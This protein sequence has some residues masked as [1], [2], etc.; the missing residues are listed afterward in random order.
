ML[1]PVV[2]NSGACMHAYWNLLQL[3]TAHGLAKTCKSHNFI[4]ILNMF[5]VLLANL[6]CL[7]IPPKTD[8]CAYSQKSIK[9]LSLFLWSM[10]LSDWNKLGLLTHCLSL[11][12]RYVI[13]LATGSFSDMCHSTKCSATSEHEPQHPTANFSWKGESTSYFQTQGS[14]DVTN[15]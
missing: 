11:V 8:P 2:K 10:Q 14:I 7:R 12:H 1:Y 6:D 9:A 4:I 15:F 3:Q 5:S 13:S